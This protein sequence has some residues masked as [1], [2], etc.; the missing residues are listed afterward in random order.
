MKFTVID[1]IQLNDAQ[2]RH[3]PDWKQKYGSD[4]L[5]VVLDPLEVTEPPVAAGAV[6][7]IHR[8]D[9]SSMKH[10]VTVAERPSTAVGLFL[11][12]L[13]S[14]DVPRLSYIETHEI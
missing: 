5:L 1:T 3:F 13:K 12:G 11:S 2:Y 4:G 9:G 10:C 7:T 14:D 8:P 6:I